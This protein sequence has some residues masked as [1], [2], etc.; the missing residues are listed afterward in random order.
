M[1]KKLFILFIILGGL[2]MAFSLNGNIQKNKEAERNR[3]Y[4]VSLVK[5]LKDSYSEIN[6][7]VISDVEFENKPTNWH[8]QLLI[9]FSDGKHIQFGTS[10][11]LTTNNFSTGGI[12]RK[13]N[14]E[15]EDLQSRKGKTVSTIK[16]IYSNGE[17]DL[18]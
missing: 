3:Q 5:K 10:Y 4:E 2:V 11:S 1:R 9:L 15:W 18:Q 16:V 7:I 13:Q 12:K 8:C 14:G 17:E 6:K